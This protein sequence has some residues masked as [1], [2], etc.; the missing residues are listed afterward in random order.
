MIANLINT[1]LGLWLVYVAIFAIP[2]GTAAS[3][4]L[5]IAGAAAAVLALIARRS[6]FSGWQSATNF[7]LGVLLAVLA[8]ADLVVPINSL[9]VFWLVLWIG[10]TVSSLALWAVLYHPE[11]QAQAYEAMAA[12][13]A[14]DGAPEPG[15]PRTA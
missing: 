2:A 4:Q 7:V 12:S 8:L 1:I 3:W 11:R 5:V 6:D 10:L 13:D 9:L 14:S 15:T